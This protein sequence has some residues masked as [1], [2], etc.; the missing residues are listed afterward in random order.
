[1]T[2]DRCGIPIARGIDT[3][4]RGKIHLCCVGC[5]FIIMVGA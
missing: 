5:N 2:C 1:M 4:I 3:P